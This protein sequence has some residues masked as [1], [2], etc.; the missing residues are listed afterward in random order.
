MRHTRPASDAWTKPPPRA[1]RSCAGNRRK[2]PRHCSP[3]AG[4]ANSGIAPRSGVQ[5]VARGETSGSEW[6]SDLRIGDAH[7]IP[8]EPLTR[9]E[10]GAP[11]A[12]QA[13]RI[14][15]SQTLHVW[16]PSQSRLRR[17]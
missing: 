2:L 16:L 9:E 13:V 15:L 11:P 3:L 5:T 8:F 7:G 1:N 17:I 14:G 4:I 10:S 12:R 6:V